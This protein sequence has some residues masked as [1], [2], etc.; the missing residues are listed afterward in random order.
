[1]GSDGVKVTKQ[2]HLPLRI[3]YKDIR[4]H[5]LQH[6]LGLSIGIGNLTLGA[7]LGNGNK[8]R[9]AVYGSRR[10]EYDVLY[11]VVS[12]LIA[13]N[14]GSGDIIIVI[15]DGLAYRLAHGLIACEMDDG[16][17]LLLIKDGV[18]RIPIQNIRL[19]KGNFLSC[20]LLHTIQSFLAGIIQVIYNN[21]VIACIQ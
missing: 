4:Q 1:M 5:L 16:I 11:A 2:H 18:Q 7:F 14:Q 8:C 10:T 13:E 3:G 17:D 12:H 20:N 21:Y 15:L 6:T 19:I 9:I